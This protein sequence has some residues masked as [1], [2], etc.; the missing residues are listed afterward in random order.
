MKNYRASFLCLIAAL[1]LPFVAIAQEQADSQDADTSSDA[2]VI[3]SIQTQ[4]T[5][6]KIT[7][8]SEDF[9]RQALPGNAFLCLL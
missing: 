7:A 6:A 4:N 1:L 9:V 3:Q 8:F 5:G 2:A